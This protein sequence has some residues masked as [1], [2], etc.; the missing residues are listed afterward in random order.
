MKKVFKTLSFSAF[1]L[2]APA[3]M[4]AQEAYAVLSDDGDTVTFYYDWDKESKGGVDIN[5][6]FLLSGSTSPYGSASTAV[7]DATFA[8][9]MPLSTA[10]WFEKCSKLGKIIGLNNLNT[11]SVIIMDRMFYNCSSLASIDLSNFNTSNVDYMLEMFHGCSSLTSLNLSNFDTSNVTDMMGMFDGCS[12]LTSLD[13]SNFDTSNVRYIWAMFNGCS[14]LT[15]L[16]VS[17]FNTANVTDLYSMFANCSSLTSLDLS[18]FNT[19]NVADMDSVFYNCSALSTIFA[20][21]GWTTEKVTKDEE[22]FFGCTS[23]VGGNGTTYDPAHI[24]HEYARIDIEGAPGYLTDK[25]HSGIN[26]ITRGRRTGA[27]TYY[28]LRGQ[29]IT[30]PQRGL[31]IVDGKKL[32]VR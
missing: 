23:L 25:T 24:G 5:S 27:S 17:N 6:D 13:L 30:A 29:R 18:N 19:S 14:S 12:S 3:T 9:F 2:M 11:A 21:D 8:N 10:C 32:L 20:G 1:M 15:S 26:V 7:F 4:Q 31:N 28:N 16:D 22:M